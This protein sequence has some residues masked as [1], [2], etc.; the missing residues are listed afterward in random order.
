MVSRAP[1]GPIAALSGGQVTV[2]IFQN[3]VGR[4]AALLV[5]RDYRYGATVAVRL[6]PETSAP[7]FFDPQHY[8]WQQGDHQH[9]TLALSLIHI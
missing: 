3:A 6:S 4:T 9:I 8:T 5:N 1:F 7:K 2:G